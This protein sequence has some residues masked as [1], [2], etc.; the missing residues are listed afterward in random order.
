MKDYLILSYEGN[1]K[2]Q[3][4]PNC[5]SKSDIIEVARRV[6][7]ENKKPITALSNIEIYKNYEIFE[8]LD[9]TFKGDIPNDFYLCVDY[10]D[11]K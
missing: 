1:V 10:S 2:I 11:Y 6:I 4:I 8:F 9:Q 3:N 5:V 7:C